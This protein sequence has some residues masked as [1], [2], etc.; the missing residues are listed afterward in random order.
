MVLALADSADKP[1]YLR[2]MDVPFGSPPTFTALRLCTVAI[3]LVDVRLR[4]DSSMFALGNSQSQ[5]SQRV[6]VSSATTNSQV[7]VLQYAPGRDR[8]R[9]HLKSPH[10]DAPVTGIRIEFVLSSKGV[11]Q[12]VIGTSNS[13]R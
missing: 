6:A 11:H 9:K 3:L 7:M 12:Y 8:S 2:A 5:D 13:D 4:R 1:A 10:G